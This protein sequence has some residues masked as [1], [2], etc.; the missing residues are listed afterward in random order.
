MTQKITSIP[1]IKPDFIAVI[2]GERVP[3]TKEW[4]REHYPK[5]ADGII[6]AAESAEKAMRVQKSIREAIS[7]QVAD[8]ESILGTTADVTQLNAAAVLALIAAFKVGD[9]FPKFRG[10]FMGTIEALVPPADGADVYAQAGAFLAAV[11][12]GEV[13]LTAALKGLPTVINEMGARSTG[14]AQVLMAASK[15]QA[16]AKEKAK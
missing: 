11:Q 13:I 8:T 2:E 6:A 16:A 15:A 10:A 1:N 5:D 7:N 4:V 9:T 14:V 12:S 3:T